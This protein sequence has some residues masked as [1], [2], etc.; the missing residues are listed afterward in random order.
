MF[1][2]KSPLLLLIALIGLGLAG[3]HECP[4]YTPPAGY[5]L[6]K[7]STTNTGSTTIDSTDASNWTLTWQKK[8]KGS[9]FL[10]SN[11]IIAFEIPHDD[12]NGVLNYPDAR[13]YLAI[14]DSGGNNVYHMVIVG[15]DGNGDDDT[16][17]LYDL[18]A[19]CPVVC[20]TSSFLYH[21]I[22]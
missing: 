18:T 11:P 6:V 5:K 3:C 9:G 15:V 7:M 14:D 12:I 22:R 10:P 17:I 16:S 8:L 1:T 2:L 19:P 13:G 21:N 4:E 20:D